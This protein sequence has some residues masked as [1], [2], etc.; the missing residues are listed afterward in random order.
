MALGILAL[1]T[2]VPIV[3]YRWVYT[4]SKRLREVTPGEFYRAGRMTG[5]GFA[6]ALRRYKIRTVINLINEEADPLLRQ[7]FLGGQVRESDI[8]KAQGVRY[9]SLPP[10]LLPPNSPPDERPA[11]IETFLELLDERSNYPVL[12]HCRAGLHRT[13]V[14]TAI[15]RMEYQSWGRHRAWEELRRNGFGDCRCFADNAYVSQYVLNYRPGVR[16]AAARPPAAAVRAD[17]LIP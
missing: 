6:E 9:V 2:V 14:F 4:H 7:S 12:I 13:G 11:S 8:C 5:D 17:V 15:Y 3:R 1:V 16:K 10:D